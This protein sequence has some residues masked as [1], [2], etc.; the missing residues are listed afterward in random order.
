MSVETPRLFP[1]KIFSARPAYL[2]ADKPRPIKPSRFSR[3]VFPRPVHAVRRRV[4]RAC[5]GVRTR[6]RISLRRVLES[7]RRD[8]A[9]N[10]LDKRLY[11]SWQIHR[12]HPARCAIP[13]IVRRL[14]VFGKSRLSHMWQPASRYPA[15]RLNKGGVVGLQG[16]K[17]FR[18]IRRGR[19][20][21]IRIPGIVT[22]HN[23]TCGAP[24]GARR[25]MEARPRASGRPYRTWG[26]RDTPQCA[27]PHVRAGTV[28]AGPRS[29]PSCVRTGS[30]Q[31]RDGG[32]D[33]EPGPDRKC[34]VPGGRHPHDA[35]ARPPRS[36][37]PPRGPWRRRLLLL[38]HGT[39]RGSGPAGPGPGPAGRR[40]RR[41]RSG[42]R[43]SR[44]R[45]GGMSAQPRARRPDPQTPGF[46]TM[47]SGIVLDRDRGVGPAKRASGV[48]GPRA[49]GRG[50]VGAWGG[51]WGAWVHTDRRERRPGI[52][53]AFRLYQARI[54]TRT[55][56]HPR[57]T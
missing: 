42:I 17:H 4:D 24:P 26:G 6:G 49:W 25:R 5:E 18:R 8:C 21:G 34:E 11:A 54:M 29:A 31:R 51:G 16:D 2:V 23:D 37:T 32:L 38:L 55:S 35:S 57:R 33:G 56:G 15:G 19:S 46:K 45:A 12:R 48:D 39:R 36:R 20:P 43:P 53:P 47:P 30:G 10:V 50:G 1:V 40:R 3:R 28:R 7:T 14:R 22:V 52:G 13:D 44:T 41:H 27:E 9:G